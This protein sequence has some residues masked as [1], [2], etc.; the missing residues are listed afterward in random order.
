ML[1]SFNAFAMAAPGLLALVTLVLVLAWGWSALARGAS[2]ATRHVVWTAAMLTVIALPIRCL[3]APSAGLVSFDGWSATS[4]ASSRPLIEEVLAD[5]EV[6]RSQQFSESILLAVSGANSADDME[7]VLPPTPAPQPEHLAAPI[8]NRGLIVSSVWVAGMLTSLSLIGLGY[9][10]LR[11]R[12]QTAD[13]FPTEMD[14]LLARL[15]TAAGIR[16]PVRGL[17]SRD[18]V[19]PM[20]W[21]V[22]NPVVL[23]PADAVNWSSQRLQIVLQHELAH[24]RRVDCLTQTIALVARAVYWFHP[25]A[26]MAV[27]QLRV[28]QEAACDD[29]VLQTGTTAPDYA[30]ELLAVTARLPR[31]LFEAS[32]ALAMSRSARIESRLRSILRDDLDRRP[33]SRLQSVTA[34][35]LFAGIVSLLVMED[36]PAGATETRPAPKPSAVAA[37]E[38]ASREAPTPSPVTKT[39]SAVQLPAVAKLATASE[40]QPVPDANTAPPKTETTKDTITIEADAETEFQ[41]LRNLIDVISTHSAQPAVRVQLRDAAINGVISSLGDQYTSIVTPEM[42]KGLTEVVDARLVGIGAALEAKG[43]GIFIRS[44]L[45]NGP[46]SKSG[47]L[48]G[49]RIVEVDGKKTSTVQETAQAIRGQ[50]G[51]DVVLSVSTK[52]EPSR[53]ITI[54]RATMELPSV[55]GINWSS[56]TGWRHMLDRKAGLG[57]IAITS[58]SRKTG[59]DFE[60]ALAKLKSEGLKGLVIDLRRNPGGILQ[61]SLRVAQL[62]LREAKFVRIAGREAQQQVLFTGPNTPYPDLPLVLVVDQ[63]TGSAAE[64]LAAALQENKRAVVVGE[65]TVGKGSIQ[66]ILPITET[67]MIRLTTHLI[68]TPSGRMLNRSPNSTVWGVDPDDDLYFPLTTDERKQWVEG[69]AQSESGQR[70][71]PEQLTPD[72]IRETLSDTLLAGAVT[73]LEGRVQTGTYTRTGKPL[74]EQQSQ[75]DQATRLKQRRD[76]LRREIEQLDAVL[77]KQP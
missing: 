44:L 4:A 12:A 15:S 32:V 41:V 47:L 76:E 69:L 64:I 63:S 20:T 13:P 14:G 75:L 9:L 43:D 50:A 60:A 56:E 11:Q 24:I 27:G 5:R 31:S 71:L 72:V 28:E 1:T 46:A 21:G 38:P 8:W 2:A 23:L 53:S 40:P 70:K 17:V 49:D 42:L 35:I 37:K 57:Y 73:A 67:N 61:E 39:P 30:S 25:L 34:A 19:M 6:A 3:V 18:S 62:F 77:G 45:P 26:W 7:I 65:R 22:W 33:A 74:S 54:R 58:F 10:R 51:T 59:E 66:S 29:R 52:G 16:R 68:S 55:V 48:P 36:R